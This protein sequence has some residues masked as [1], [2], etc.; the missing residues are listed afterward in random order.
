MSRIVS[1][2]VLVAITL[3][4]SF[5]FYKVLAG[6][7]VPLFLAVVLVVVF[8]PLHRWMLGRTNQRAHLAAGLTTL[9]ILTCLLFPIGLVVSVAG[10]QGLRFVEQNSVASIELQ[11]RKLRDS[12]GLDMPRW[13][14]LLRAASDEVDILMREISDAT[15]AQRNVTL[16][17]LGRKVMRSLEEVKKEMIVQYGEQWDSQQIDEIIELAAGIGSPPIEQKPAESQPESSQRPT[18]KQSSPSS[19]SVDSTE[20]VDDEWN[21]AEQG[22]ILKTQFGALKASLHGGS[23]AMFAR[24]FANPTGEDVESLQQRAVEYLRPRLISITRAT[25]QTAFH[26]IFGLLI[27]TVSVYFFLVDGPSMIQT[28]LM[29]LPLD[30]NYE[31]ELVEEFA[32][33]SRAVVVAMLL[34]AMTQGLIAGLGYAVAGMDYLVLLIMLTTL[35]A[36]IPFVGPMIVWVP[37][38]VYIAFVE[39]RFMA[40]GLLAT[41]GVLVVGTIDNF[42]KA[43]VLHGQSQLHPLLALLS[44]LGGVQTLGP[45]G[46][47]VGPMAVSMLQTLLGIVRRELVH[48]DTYGLAARSDGTDE[49]QR[50]K[51]KSTEASGPESPVTA[52]R[53]PNATSRKAGN[54]KGRK[55]S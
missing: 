50:S 52:S 39:E 40:A 48:F 33:T 7:F 21:P 49:A 22:L 45:I 16:P 3:V 53:Q 24:E 28:I 6:F 23:L 42:V 9:M 1:F 51:L 18:E 55:G 46:I 36:L 2:A 29:L 25:G 31:I 44:I 19:S 4:I 41:W 10:V 38:C 47:V 14:H 5:L 11:L 15:I 8:Q 20:R 27:L 43:F 30:V 54:N 35:A 32:R 12:L 37:V 13:G 17:G 26:V 34:A